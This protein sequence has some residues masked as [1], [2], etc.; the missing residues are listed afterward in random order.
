MLYTVSMLPKIYRLPASQFQSVFRT[1]KRIH[2]DDLTYVIQKTTEKVSR[3]A[4]V[5]SK[6]VAKR[7][8]DRNRIKRMLRESIHNLLPSIQPGYD[9]IFMVKNNFA[10]KTSKEITTRISD[11]FRSI[12]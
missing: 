8:V 1:G 2:V 11:L 10:D 12:R 6:K 3:F 7:A 9:I 4:F 5:V